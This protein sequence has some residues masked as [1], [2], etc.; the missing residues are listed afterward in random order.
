[1]IPFIRAGE[2]IFSATPTTLSLAMMAGMIHAYPW[3]AIQ[4][5]WTAT[6]HALVAWMLFGSLA[7]LLLYILLVPVLRRLV[8]SPQE[9]IS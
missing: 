1:L 4:L 2:W 9:V 7:T 3:I 6:L 5:L 8:R